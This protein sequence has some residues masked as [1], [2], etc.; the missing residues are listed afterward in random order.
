MLFEGDFR[1]LE[2]RVGCVM[3]GGSSRR[4]IVC[5]FWEASEGLWPRDVK[6]SIVD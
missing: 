5:M 3:G 1:F 4:R 2:E 6:D